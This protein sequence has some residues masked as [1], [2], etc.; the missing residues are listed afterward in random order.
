MLFLNHDIIFI[1]FLGS[2]KLSPFPLCL[3]HID[4]IVG[5]G[6]G[7]PFVHLPDV[8]P[9]DDENWLLEVDGGKN[10]ICEG[11]SVSC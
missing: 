5:N 1:C 3:Y 4:K 2:L 10:N 6:A 9:M 7:H 11:G 8:D